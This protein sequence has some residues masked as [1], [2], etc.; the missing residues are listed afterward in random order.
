MARVSTAS[1]GNRRASS[2]DQF[3]RTMV[4]N[5]MASAGTSFSLWAFRIAESFQTF[6]AD[7]WLSDGAV[8]GIAM[9]FSLHCPPTVITVGRTVG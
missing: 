9:P 7:E 1:L 8:A 6:G 5:G 2:E 3:E 4:N